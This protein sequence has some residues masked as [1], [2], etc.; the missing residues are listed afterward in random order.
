ML[1]TN[2][3]PDLAHGRTLRILHHQ[4]LDN[5][6][7]DIPTHRSPV[8]QTPTPHPL[9]AIIRLL[10]VLEAV[11]S[12]SWRRCFRRGRGCVAEGEFFIRGGLGCD[13]VAIAMVRN[14]REATRQ[15]SCRPFS[16]NLQMMKSHDSP[17]YSAIGGIRRQSTPFENSI[18]RPSRDSE[19]V[20]SC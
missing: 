19:R 20:E 13:L 3:L 7:D 18:P 5:R 15:A 2:N 10:R 1:R 16:R 12:L 8:V 14:I 6:L 9:W 11:L 17:A 4:I